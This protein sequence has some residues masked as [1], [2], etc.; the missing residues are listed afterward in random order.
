MANNGDAVKINCYECG[1]EMLA[2]REQVNTGEPLY[3]TD[4]LVQTTCSSCGQD[5]RM[6]KEQFVEVNGD[7]VVCPSCNSQTTGGSSENAFKYALGAFGVILLSGLVYYL[8]L[9][10]PIG[11]F[12]QSHQEAVGSVLVAGILLLWRFGS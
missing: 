2:P 10:Y 3:C 8:A 1:S 12:I 11:S 7:P 9:N 4:C 5:I 6:T